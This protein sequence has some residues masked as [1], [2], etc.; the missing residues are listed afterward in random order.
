MISAPPQVVSLTFFHCLW[1][2]FM[3]NIQY[4]L[5]ESTNNKTPSSLKQPRSSEPHW[6]YE[7]GLERGMEVGSFL[8]CGLG[9]RE[10][11]GFIYTNHATYEM[12]VQ[13]Q[14][15]VN[16]KHTQSILDKSQIKAHLV[17]FRWWAVANRV[18]M[19]EDDATLADP[20]AMT[21]FLEHE[22]H[23]YHVTANTKIV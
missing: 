4:C 5:S 13:H 18:R 14:R 19:D 12:V 8:W 20:L 10:V 7:E 3:L 16:G 21:A 22:T 17:V 1:C 6:P 23:G 9:G 15:K 2:Y 11:G